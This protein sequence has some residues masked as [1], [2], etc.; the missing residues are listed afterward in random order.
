MNSS[1]SGF[2]R[3]I[4]LLALWPLLLNPLLAQKPGANAGLPKV[5]VWET[6]KPGSAGTVYLVGSIHMMTEKE[7]P[8]PAPFD[9][10]FEQSSRILFE[11]PM[12]TMA[13]PETQLKMMEMMTLPEGKTIKTELSGPTHNALVKAIKKSSLSTNL[14]RMERFHPAFL[15]MMLT[16]SQIQ[17][18]GGSSAHGLDIHFYKKAVKANKTLGA[19]ETWD[20]QMNALKE[21]GTTEGEKLVTSTLKQLE[22]TDNYFKNVLTAWKNGDSAKLATLLEEGNDEFPALH[23]TLILKRN[24][25]WLPQIEKLYT[26]P[27]HSMVIVGAGHLVGKGSLLDLLKAKGI[28][29]V[30]QAGVPRAVVVP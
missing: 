23:E 21:L 28:T 10:A 5:P 14:P 26:G 11:A 29:A 1:H 16:L 17:K 2:A 22:K 6:T 15:T 13:K 20:Y 7:Y 25:A 27:T 12:E 18:A 3:S 8:L 24:Q 30:Q 9:E 19:L 4:A